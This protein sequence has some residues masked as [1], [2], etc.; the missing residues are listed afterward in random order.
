MKNL[1]FHA[2]NIFK[3][4]ALIIISSEL[5]ILRALICPHSLIEKTAVINDMPLIFEYLSFSIVIYITG[6]ILWCILEK[7][8]CKEK[9]N[10]D[11]SL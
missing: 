9:N 6:F 8:I 4:L 7:K 1:K 5:G 10:T 11:F 3:L 2:H